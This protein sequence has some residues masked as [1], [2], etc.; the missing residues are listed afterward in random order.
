MNSLFTG[1]EH[2][3]YLLKQFWK[4]TLI[5]IN[6]LL[7]TSIFLWNCDYFHEFET[8]PSCEIYMFLC[9]IIFCFYNKDLLILAQ[10]VWLIMA[11][12]EI[13]L[14]SFHPQE[15]RTKTRFSTIAR[16][17]ENK[18]YQF[19]FGLLLIIGRKYAPRSSWVKGITQTILVI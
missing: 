19:S 3:W 4:G 10:N 1:Y 5:L 8:V 12:L 6:S 16:E 13:S 15:E 7:V 17:L 9:E 18:K 14:F 11:N 2:I